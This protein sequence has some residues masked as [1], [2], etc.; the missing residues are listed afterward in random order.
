[1][2]ADVALAAAAVPRM[3]SSAG[4]DKVRGPR[5]RPSACAHPG[6]RSS[7]SLRDRQGGQVA[8]ESMALAETSAAKT[9]EAAA[10]AALSSKADLIDATAECAVA[11]VGEAEARARYRAA[12]DGAAERS[13]GTAEPPRQREEIA[14]GVLRWGVTHATPD[15]PRSRQEGVDGPERQVTPMPGARRGRDIARGEHTGWRVAFDC[16]A[17]SFLDPSI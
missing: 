6:H 1:M 14:P 15:A 5:L 12:S 9:A 4:W 8:L 17:A 13:G 3:I 11:D 7:L 16:A 2:T 10:L